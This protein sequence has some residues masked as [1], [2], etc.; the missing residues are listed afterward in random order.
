MTHPMTH[1]ISLTELAKKNLNENCE[2]NVPN[3]TI[4]NANSSEQVAIVIVKYA[5]TNTNPFAVPMVK[6]TNHCAF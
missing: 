2:V 3:A 5:K 1:P 4:E 6:R